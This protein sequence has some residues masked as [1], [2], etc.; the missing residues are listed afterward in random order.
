MEKEY[1]EPFPRNI[2]Q[3]FSQLRLMTWCQPD[4]CCNLVLWLSIPS[5][6]LRF[7]TSVRKTRLTQ[8]THFGFVFLQTAASGWDQ[9]CLAV[10]MHSVSTN[11]RLK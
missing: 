3:T 5:F 7:W 8:R 4:V 11:W 2:S 10:K 6:M 1:T 9:L